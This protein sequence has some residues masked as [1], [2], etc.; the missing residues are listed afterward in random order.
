MVFMVVQNKEIEIYTWDTCPFCARA[1]EL[2]KQKEL[3][4]KQIK[5]DG[6]EAAREEM[7]KK[8]KGNRK[9]VP[10]IFIAGVSIGGCDDLYALEDKGDL[11]KL[12]A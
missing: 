2:L 11:D 4:F 1:L 6:N 12:L 10:Q 5:V 7:S 3:K 8:T 9:S